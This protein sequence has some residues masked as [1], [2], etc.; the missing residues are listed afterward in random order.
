MDYRAI[1]LSTSN[2]LVLQDIII[3]KKE[4]EPCE[5][6]RVYRILVGDDGPVIAL[7]ERSSQNHSF[8]SAF[9]ASPDEM[10]PRLS[11]FLRCLRKNLLPQNTQIASSV[12]GIGYA[13]AN[14]L[15]RIPAAFTKHLILV[16][17]DE[18]AT[19]FD[20]SSTKYQDFILYILDLYVFLAEIA[21]V[22]L[23]TL[24]NLVS[25]ILDMPHRVCIIEKIVLGITGAALLTKLLA[26]NSLIC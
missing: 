25:K 13:T 23:V 18:P 26:K 20:I 22:S 24:H 21:T 17:A 15:I 4:P 9:V 7:L 10:L 11:H 19:I 16:L 1:P 6:E 12:G 2:K 8:R 5:Y 14:K 3:S